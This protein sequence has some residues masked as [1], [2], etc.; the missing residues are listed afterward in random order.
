LEPTRTWLSRARPLG[1][2]HIA[3]PSARHSLISLTP[4]EVLVE[5]S[6]GEPWR[7]STYRDKTLS[8]NIASS[9]VLTESIP[10]GVLDALPAQYDFQRRRQSSNAVSH[11]STGTDR[12]KSLFKNHR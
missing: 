1:G 11:R 5:Y 2:I 9:S 10:M 3:F 8:Q 4:L 6:E 12:R 7:P